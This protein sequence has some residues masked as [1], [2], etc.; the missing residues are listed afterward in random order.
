MYYFV[1]RFGRRSMLMIGSAIMLLGMWF[2]GAYIKIA[3]PSAANSELTASG[4][5]AVTMIYIYAIGYCFSFAGIPWIYA[6][7]IFPL[8]IRGIG[9]AACTA[10]HWLFNF[11]IARS[12][13]YM[14]TNIGYGTYFIFATC[15]TLS[16][17]FVYFCLPE[18][19]GLSLEEV[20]V[21]FEGP[22]ADS[23]ILVETGKLPEMSHVE[24]LDVEVRH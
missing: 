13:P 21:L 9:M 17:P 11:A 8:Q 22:R 16:I 15:I 3:A 14:I 24:H 1:D 20:D 6:S 18:T 19:K 2:I 12:V 4:Y 10:T 5:A 23:D 7:E